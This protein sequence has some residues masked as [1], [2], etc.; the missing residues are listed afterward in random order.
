MRKLVLTLILVLGL[1]APAGAAVTYISFGENSFHDLGVVGD[2]LV[3]A[4]SNDACRA[5]ILFKSLD[6]GATWNRITELTATGNVAA[7]DGVI[8]MHFGSDRIW[9]TS[10]IQTNPY[11][12]G[13]GELAV[14]LDEGATW[15][16]MNDYLDPLFATASRPQDAFTQARGCRFASYGSMGNTYARN[17]GTD[18]TVWSPNATD[19]MFDRLLG[20]AQR[21]PPGRQDRDGRDVV[22]ALVRPG[23]DVLPAPGR[24]FADRLFPVRLADLH[25][26]RPDDKPGHLAGQRKRRLRSGHGGSI[27]LGHLR[28]GDR[29]PD[30][31]PGRSD[32]DRR[33]GDQR[34]HGF[35]LRDHN[36]GWSGPLRCPDD[37]QRR[38]ILDPAGGRG[39]RPRD[40]PDQRFG[41]KSLRPP[42]DPG[43]PRFGRR[44]RRPLYPEHGLMPGASPKKSGSASVGPARIK[45]LVRLSAAVLL[46]LALGLPVCLITA[47]PVTAGPPVDRVDQLTDRTA[48]VEQAAREK[49][50][51]WEA[52]RT[53]RLD[54]L[55]RLKA[56]LRWLTFQRRRQAAY[57]AK[58]EAAVEALKRRR[59]EVGRIN[60]ELEPFLAET[61]DRLAG[62]TARDLPFLARERAK[63]IQFL[64][65]SLTDYRLGLSEKFRRVM[66]ALLVE[67]GY[68]RGVEAT[69][70]TIDLAGRPTEVEVLRLGRLALFFRTPDGSRMGWRT[71]A[72]QTWQGLPRSEARQLNLALDMARR[73]RA[74]DLIQLPVG[75]PDESMG[76]PNE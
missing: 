13:G 60:R 2:G 37:L 24:R 6:N 63:R 69:E 68:G 3:Y 17:C 21:A 46:G 45:G 70:E 48:R 59:I 57:T 33:P 25:Q 4:S 39:Q 36:R 19:L 14:S 42:E 54:E 40:Q 1:A 34:Q 12:L 15:Q 51:N 65:D 20:D 29:K 44:L 74:V 62:F 22:S 16:S 67:A 7:A 75:R 41:R 76:R 52:E 47:G 9:Y 10:F 43:R 38:P 5:F 27:H 56:E 31:H 30:N 18:L 71:R 49:V 35:R 64:R 66:E 58:R 28:R 55:S 73:R 32:R 50:R 23:D 26:D 53:E 8:K 11:A 61:V 72:D